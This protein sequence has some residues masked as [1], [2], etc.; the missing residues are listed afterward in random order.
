MRIRESKLTRQNLGA[1][2]MRESLH[3]TLSHVS[4]AVEEGKTI[5][6][7]IELQ[8]YRKARTRNPDT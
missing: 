8:E 4:I 6:E 1:K 2:A 7:V 3:S 5:E